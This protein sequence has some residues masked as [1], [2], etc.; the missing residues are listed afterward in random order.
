MVTI[1]FTFETTE[2]KSYTGVVRRVF[3]K[4]VNNTRYTCGSVEEL[5]ERVKN[6]SDLNNDGA[7]ADY[8]RGKYNGD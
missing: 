6:H 4:T 3:M 5:K 2:T 8:G 7:A 1:N